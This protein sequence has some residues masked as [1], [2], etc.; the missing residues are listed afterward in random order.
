MYWSY[1]ASDSDIGPPP[2]RHLR[3]GP[4]T[5]QTIELIGIRVIKHQD[6][7]VKRNEKKK[8]SGHAPVAD[9]Q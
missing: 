3:G 7:H 8:K 9:D 4:K 6:L 5:F 1:P 2:D